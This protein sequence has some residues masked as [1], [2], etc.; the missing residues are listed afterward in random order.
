VK[1]ADASDKDEKLKE[2]ESLV[3]DTVETIKPHKEEQELKMLFQKSDRRREFSV[4]FN[5]EPTFQIFSDCMRTAAERNVRHLLLSGHGQSRWGFFWLKEGALEYEKIPTEKFVGLF[6]TEV[7]GAY[8]RGTIEGVVL[9]AC[10]TEGLG[11]KLRDAGVPHVVCWRSEVYDA[12]A[13]AFSR[14]FFTSFEENKNYKIS[15]LQTVDR[16]FPGPGAKNLHKKHLHRDAVDYVCLL[17]KDGDEFLDTGHIR[18]RVGVGD[19]EDHG[20]AVPNWRPPTAYAHAL[21]TLAVRDDVQESFKDDGSA[22]ASLVEAS[23]SCEDAEAV[24]ATTAGWAGARD[25]AGATIDSE[26]YIGGVIGEEEPIRN[27][28]NPTGKDDHSAQAG[29]HERDALTS[30]KFEMKVG[31][32]IVQVGNGIVAANGFLSIEVLAQWGICKYEELWGARGKTVIKAQA[33]VAHRDILQR[34]VKSLN[35]ALF[36]RKE[37][38][39]KQAQRRKCKGTCPPRSCRECAMKSTHEYMERLIRASKEEIESL[40]SSAATRSAPGPEPLHVPHDEEGGVLIEI[41]FSQ[42]AMELQAKDAAAEISRIRYETELQRVRA[43]AE[44]QGLIHEAEMERLKAEAKASK[45]ESEA[46]RL[47][48][49]AELL[50]LSMQAQKTSGQQTAPEAHSELEMTREEELYVAGVRAR[51][52]EE[53]W[54]SR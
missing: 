40:L 27:W 46:N 17:S 32:K 51:M 24:K 41:G 37:D 28:R 30:L 11:K 26:A 16:I 6:R 9:N 7:A 15:F 33:L 47:K 13:S 48:Q 19:S 29:K 54:D 14:E 20:D 12:T 23:A 22:G 39:K 10:D 35:E 53:G 49:E 3:S 38:M 1:K 18:G 21:P 4:S 5:P 50:R 25:G 36:Q 52:M 45:A 42:S 2:L 34:V 31:G 8:G 43:E 44:I